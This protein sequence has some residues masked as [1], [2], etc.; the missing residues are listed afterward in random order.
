MT[1]EMTTTTRGPTELRRIMAYRRLA[2]A[3]LGLDPATLAVDLQM[4]R[5]ARE[6]LTVERREQQRVEEVLA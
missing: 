3:I 4:Q 5:M 1:S 6:R 2:A